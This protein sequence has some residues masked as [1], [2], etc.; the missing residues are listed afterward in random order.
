MKSERGVIRELSRFN[1]RLAVKG[2]G[3]ELTGRRGM[4]GGVVQR[5]V[6]RVE[7]G[8]ARSRSWPQERGRGGQKRTLLRTSRQHGTLQ[9]QAAAAGLELLPSGNGVAAGMGR[10]G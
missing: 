1:S 9:N 2:I 6:A 4:A 5:R 10:K 3:L 8:M 7:E